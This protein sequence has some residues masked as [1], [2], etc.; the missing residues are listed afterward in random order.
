MFGNSYYQRTVKAT[1]VLTEGGETTITLNVVSVFV[2]DFSRG[3]P[4]EE[5]IKI[6]LN[7][8][9][10]FDCE[11]VYKTKEMQEKIEMLLKKADNGEDL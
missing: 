4:T 11:S 3:N 6:R 1:E 2:D 5:T 8:E 10:T 7:E 9:L